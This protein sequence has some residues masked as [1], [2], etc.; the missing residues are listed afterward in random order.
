EQEVQ[1]VLEKFDAYARLI[2]R[3]LKDVGQND[4]RLAGMGTTLTAAYTVGLD[5]FLG[6]IGDTRAY[7]FRQGKLRQLTRD[8]TLAQHMLELG[9][10]TPGALELRR[11]RHILTNSLGAGEHA[12]RADVRHLKLEDGDRLLLCSDGLTDMVPDE[13]I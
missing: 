7:L 12:A 6:H 8:H 5:A 11:L 1:E 2:D 9:A 10:L 13:Q 3:K 4:P